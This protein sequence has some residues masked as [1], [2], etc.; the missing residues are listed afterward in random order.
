MRGSNV[1]HLRVAIDVRVLA[2]R[3]LE[4]ELINGIAPVDVDDPERHPTMRAE[5][6]PVRRFER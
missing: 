5:R 1:L 3:A 6:A 4:G 2:V